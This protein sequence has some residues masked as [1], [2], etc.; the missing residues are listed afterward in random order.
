MAARFPKGQ[1]SGPERRGSRMAP[2]RRNGERWRSRRY[3]LSWTPTTLTA[4]FN[5]VPCMTDVYASYLSSPDTAPAPFN[6]PFFLAFT[7]ALGMGSNSPGSCASVFEH[8]EDRLGAGL[9]VRLRIQRRAN[10][11]A[12]LV[13][14]TTCQ[15]GSCARIDR[16]R[17]ARRPNDIG[18]V[19]FREH[20][21]G[22]GR[23]A[24]Q[25]EELRQHLPLEKVGAT[26]REGGTVSG[27]RV[28]APGV[29]GEDPALMG[30]EVVEGLHG[31][32]RR[33]AAR[34]N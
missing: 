1:V 29:F 11:K 28:V 26:V 34:G 12:T 32:A 17:G 25:G 10:T 18:D 19:V 7:A 13:R 30:L 33:D 6:Q 3:A 31:Q 9:A 24:G 15:R 22:V 27:D 16:Q 20:R 2:R 8:D 23:H 21:V 4:Y 14:S 5:G